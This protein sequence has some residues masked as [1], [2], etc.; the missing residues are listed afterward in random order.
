MHPLQRLERDTGLVIA[1]ERLIHDAH[2]ALAEDA[3]NLEPI[4][5]LEALG[6]GDESLRPRESF[7]AQT[8]TAVCF[9]SNMQ[10]SVSEAAR[11]DSRGRTH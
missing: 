11:N 10:T 3:P 5:A 8:E 4:R 2:P 9:S 6:Q 7:R 1:I